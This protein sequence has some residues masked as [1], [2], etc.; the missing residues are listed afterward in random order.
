MS[1]ILRYSNRES[2]R[3]STIESNRHDD[4]NNPTTEWPTFSVCSPLTGLHCTT[5]VCDLIKLPVKDK[6]KHKISWVFFL[7]MLI[8][9]IQVSF[10]TPSLE[11][12]V[13]VVGD[14]RE[15]CVN[16]NCTHE[17]HSHFCFRYNVQSATFYSLAIAI[18]YNLCSII[19]FKLILLP[20]RSYS[21]ISA[22][23][24]PAQCS[25]KSLE[26]SHRLWVFYVEHD[27]ARREKKCWAIFAREYFNHSRSKVFLR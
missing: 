17:S 12:S 8:T 3:S 1:K 15:I 25:R 22:K 13:S 2:T 11:A 23:S 21:S 16:G 20:S 14:G 4:S 5:F 10:L 19:I 18:K 9:S 6:E 27:C 24:K 7:Y 26:I